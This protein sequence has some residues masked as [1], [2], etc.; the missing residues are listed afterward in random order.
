MLQQLLSFS[1]CML[2]FCSYILRSQ[3]SVLYFILLSESLFEQVCFPKICCLLS[4]N[5]LLIKSLLSLNEGCLFL[6]VKS[7]QCLLDLEALLKFNSEGLRDQ[8]SSL[9]LA[10]QGKLF[11]LA[12]K[13]AF[14]RAH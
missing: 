2:E 1:A 9:N 6:Q 10:F 13:D 11:L 7:L 8:V 3:I 5:S 4:F 14:F 12:A